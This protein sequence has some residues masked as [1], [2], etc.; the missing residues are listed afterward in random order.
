MEQNGHADANLRLLYV[1]ALQVATDFSAV[2]KNRKGAA[3]VFDHFHVIKLMNEKL[4]QLRRDLYHEATTKF[5]WRR[6]TPS[7]KTYGSCGASPPMPLPNASCPIGA[8]KP[9]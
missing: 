3:L 8:S 2:I 4:T 7:R 5:H 9:M 6:R 1:N